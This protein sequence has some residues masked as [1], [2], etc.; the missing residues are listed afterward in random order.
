MISDKL[1]KK[2]IISQKSILLAYISSFYIVYSIKL[3]LITNTHQNVFCF[4]SSH[5]PLSSLIFIEICMFNIL[6]PQTISRGATLAYARPMRTLGF[7]TL[8]SFFLSLFQVL[9]SRD[10]IW[11]LRA[12]KTC[13]LVVWSQAHIIRYCFICI[14]SSVRFKL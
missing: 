10:C 7:I 1:N 9:N 12:T 11:P 13:R 6:S 3:F 2:K 5:N 14:I 4:S 8:Y